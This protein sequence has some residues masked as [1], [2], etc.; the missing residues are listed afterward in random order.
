[1]NIHRYV[2]MKNVHNFGIKSQA[3]A[4]SE[5]GAINH[6]GGKKTLKLW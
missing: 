3:T 1:M 5:R 4:D 2:T 6:F